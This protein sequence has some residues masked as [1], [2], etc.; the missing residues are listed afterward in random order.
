VGKNTS[1]R[2][3]RRAAHRLR[4]TG[5][6]A[7]IR[8]WLHYRTGKKTASFSLETRKKSPKYL[9]RLVVE[10]VFCEIYLVAVRYFS[11]QLLFRTRFNNEP[12]ANNGFIPVI[13]A[14]FGFLH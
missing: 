13:P 4:P 11:N 5:F 12:I 1:R 2:L 7:K 3:S 10:C 14:Y 6:R 9:P 8:I